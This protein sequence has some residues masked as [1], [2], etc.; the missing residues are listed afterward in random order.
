[1][2][3]LLLLVCVVCLMVTAPVSAVGN[4]VL[5]LPWLYLEIYTF[6]EQPTELPSCVCGHAL[7]DPGPPPVYENID[8]L[9]CYVP[10][11]PYE[12]AYVPIHTATGGEGF[13]GLRG[14]NFGIQVS[15]EPVDFLGAFA[16]Q[17]FVEGPGV[18]PDAIC[19]LSTGS[20][21]D[22]R[23]HS[24]YTLWFNSSTGTGATYFDIVPN[25]D[26]GN[27]YAMDCEYTWSMNT[28]VRG[29][30]QWGGTKTIGCGCVTGPTSVQATTWGN[31][32]DLYR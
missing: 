30:A 20:C 15:G 11:N 32:K 1:M 6:A 21:Y 25:A 17:G 14:N 31:I 10:K 19:F 28:V 9:P 22:W 8:T 4:P 12:F 27:Y 24:G 26:S 18:G 5:A 2:K 29:R 3:T 7:L 16:C 13:P 23:N